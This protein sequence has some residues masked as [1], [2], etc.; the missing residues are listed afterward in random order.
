MPF[1]VLNGDK[2]TTVSPGCDEQA[3]LQ[4]LRT[5]NLVLSGQQTE[6]LSL[7]P[8]SDH[9][10]AKPGGYAYDVLSYTKP[11]GCLIGQHYV[12]HGMGHYWS[13]GTSNPAYSAYTDPKGPSASAAS[14]AFF[15][16]YTLRGS[17]GSCP[18]MP[19]ARHKAKPHA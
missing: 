15:S 3:V 7:T 17:N 18:T 6:P 8:S 10:A 14:W 5:D 11:G 19:K 2:D 4:W 1:I 9:T 16:H 12:I 13:G